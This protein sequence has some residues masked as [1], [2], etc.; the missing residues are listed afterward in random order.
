MM[1]IAGEAD[2]AEAPRSRVG[3]E[4]AIFDFLSHED[5]HHAFNEGYLRLVR[6]A[7]PSDRIVFRAV[8]GHADRLAPRIVD[9]EGVELEAAPPFF[10]PLGLSRHNPIAG[11]WAA[12]QC[13]AFMAE[14]VASRS[15]RLTAL[16]GVDAN[17][18]ATVGQKWPARSA[19]PLH[20]ILHG[21]LGRTLIGRS[22][23]P[24][25]RAGDFV[26]AV[27]RK[28]PAEVRL[29]ALELG[30][31]EAIREIAPALVPSI[32]TLEH[33]ILAREWGPEPPAEPNPVP[34]I[35]FLGH[36][37]LTK[38]FAVFADLANACARPDLEFLAIGVGSSETGELDMSALTVKP[39][40]TPLPRHAYLAGLAEID[41]VCLPLHGRVYDFTAS[42][43]VSDAIAALKPL[44]AFRNRTL[45]AIVYQYGEIGYLV[46]SRE[47]MFALVRSFDH[48]D[49]ARRRPG[50]ITNLRKIRDARRPEALAAGY[51]TTIR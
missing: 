9:M 19:S 27:G 21:Q 35:G 12:R 32:V 41:L 22:R 33:P 4:I 43:T 25:F 42:G 45:D 28:L 20:M 44:I 48:A 51:R 47:A 31:P 39:S 18:F 50:W 16:L 38:G 1:E 8:R 24:V 30:V 13:L 36:A 5:M 2:I 11:R 17:L 49:F 6:A 14:A 37:R 34:R 40:P 46:D 23:N 10:V 7:F 29:V 26:S 3:S 15:P